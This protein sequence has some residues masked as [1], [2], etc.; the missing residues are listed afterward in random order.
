[1]DS[2]QFNANG[3]PK[4]IS[5]PKSASPLE[6]NQDQSK[7]SA[8]QSKIITNTT[9][10][11]RP[12]PPFRPC[13]RGAMQLSKAIAQYQSKTDFFAEETVRWVFCTGNP[14]CFAKVLTVPSNRNESV[15]I[16]P[17]KP[18]LFDSNLLILWEGHTWLAKQCKLEPVQVFS[19]NHFI[20]QI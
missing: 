1:M 20:C 6:F 19:F 5:K 15:C 16:Q 3:P 2:N 4:S 13:G 8:F 14:P 17:M 18:S 7:D 11:T 10:I 9:N 12:S